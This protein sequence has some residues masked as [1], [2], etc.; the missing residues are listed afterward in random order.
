MKKRNNAW[1]LLIKCSKFFLFPAI[2]IFGCKEEPVYWHVK[3]ED[4]VITE[5][6]AS[7]PETTEFSKILDATGLNSLLSVR[8]PFTLFLPTDE[9]MKA[10]YTAKG[11][12]SYL[13]FTDPDFLNDLVLN[14]LI[15]NKIETND[16]GLG[17]IRDIN[18]LG[19]YLITEFSGSDIILNKQ[20]KIIK[21][22]IP[23]ANGVIHMI[24]AVID[25]VTLSVYDVIAN[26]PSF[27]I[28]AEGLKRTKLKDT[29]QLISFPYGQKQA[30][31]RFTILAVA[32]TTFNRYDINNIDELIAY[33]TDAPDSITYLNN[34]FYRYMEYHCLNETYFLNTFE[35]GTYPILSYDNNISVRIDTDYKL[36]FNSA[37][38]KY[39]GFVI[40]QSNFPA[41]NGTVHTIKDLLPVYEPEA[42]SFVL[43]TTDYFDMRQ[44]DYFGKYYMRWFDGQNTFQYIKWEGDYLLYYYKNHDTGKLLNDDCLSMSGWWWVQVTTRKIMKGKYKLTSN[45]WSGHTNYAVYVD[46]VNTAIVKSSDPAETT[47]W[48]EFDWTTTD[49]HTI[50]V[51]TLS[52]GLL[53]W[54]TLIFTAIK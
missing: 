3:S 12:S 19:D 49:R 15:P 29:L 42:T 4:Q 8:G 23:A 24:D 26:N 54:D 46:G 39:T 35:T 40:D 7:N 10:Y 1:H 6:V 52:P 30:R 36:N 50:K 21:K 45:L 20:S 18:A 5:Y 22:D 25:P 32:D 17:A 31:T 33:F 34:K 47:S 37:T 11:V 48:G 13:D 16:F 51:V 14:H 44:G 9:A 53:F 38:N 43:E 27:S 28:F 2:L 41:K